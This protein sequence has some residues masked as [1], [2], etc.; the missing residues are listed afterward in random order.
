MGSSKQISGGEVIQII[1]LLQQGGLFWM[2]PV[3]L[4]HT[5]GTVGLVSCIPGLAAGILMIMQWLKFILIIVFK[6]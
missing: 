1:L 3:M 2:L 5:N 4:I 6:E